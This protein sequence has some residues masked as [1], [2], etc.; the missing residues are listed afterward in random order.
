MTKEKIAPAAACVAF[1][2]DEQALSRRMA[3]QID[4]A[5]GMIRLA[6]EMREQ[7]VEMRK[8]SRRKNIVKP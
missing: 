7:A 2:V 5:K 6:R 8:N 4:N 3:E 1:F